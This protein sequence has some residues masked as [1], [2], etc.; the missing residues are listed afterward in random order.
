MHNDI[1]GK[2]FHYFQF[3]RDT[4]YLGKGLE[5]VS[6]ILEDETDM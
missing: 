3:F 6:P 4:S 2:A 1:A 5:A